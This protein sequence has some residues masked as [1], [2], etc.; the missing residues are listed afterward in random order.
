MMWFFPA[1][2]AVIVVLGSAA[3][4]IGSRYMQPSA[5]IVA[6]VFAITA[7]SWVALIVVSISL[8]VRSFAATV[9]L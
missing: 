4:V 9:S 2:L 1:V 6:F 5:G 7:I 8:M 3:I